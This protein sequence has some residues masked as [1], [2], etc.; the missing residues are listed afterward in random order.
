MDGALLDVATDSPTM[1]SQPSLTLISTSTIT[2]TIT[3]SSTPTPVPTATYA[4]IA[5]PEG[6]D[7]GMISYIAGIGLQEA[8]VFLA[9]ADGSHA[10]QVISESSILPEGWFFSGVEI[11]I[12]RQRIVISAGGPESSLEYSETSIYVLDLQNYSVTEVYIGNGSIMD[13]DLSSDGE[14]VVYMRPQ[15]SDS[16]S[17]THME[18][19]HIE[20][21][22]VSRLVDALDALE[23]LRG[24]EDEWLDGYHVFYPTWSPEGDRILYLIRKGDVRFEMSGHIADITCDQQRHHCQIESER[25]FDWALYQYLFWANGTSQILGIRNRLSGIVEIDQYEMDGTICNHITL[26]REPLDIDQSTLYAPSPDGRFLA[27][28]TRGSGFYLLDLDTEEL[29]DLSD[30]CLANAGQFDWV[31]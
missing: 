14:Y 12:D 22:T 30:T 2:T 28:N 24:L 17:Y 4:P 19:L 6:C 21:Q 9:C 26:D 13:M 11:S 3:P 31:P 8:A 25:R 23:E 15:F 29:I 10:Q 1:T 18:V 20:S 27:I 7:L 5:T 16:L